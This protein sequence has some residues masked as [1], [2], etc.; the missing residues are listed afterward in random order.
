M[1]S[2]KK[3]AW[4]RPW[5][6]EIQDPN[7]SSQWDDIKYGAGFWLLWLV[8]LGVIALAVLGILQALG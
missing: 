6:E 1:N 2:N 3:A 8:V 4:W 5:T 7:E